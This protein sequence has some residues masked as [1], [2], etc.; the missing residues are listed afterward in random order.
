MRRENA[1]TVPFGKRQSLQD[2]KIESPLQEIRCMHSRID[3]LYVSPI[4]C[5]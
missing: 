2:Q 5:Q 4:E 3:T 1:E